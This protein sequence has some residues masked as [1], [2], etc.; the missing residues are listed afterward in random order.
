MKNDTTHKGMAYGF[1]LMS[2]YC[3][4]YTLYKKEMA[5][6]M[7]LKFITSKVIGNDVTE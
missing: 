7:I 6:A 1:L 3:K 2:T 5:K 4:N